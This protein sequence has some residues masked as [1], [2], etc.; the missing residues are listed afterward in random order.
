VIRLRNS[1]GLE[2]RG[3]LLWLERV[4][5]TDGEQGLESLRRSVQ[6]GRPF[7]QPQWQKETAKRL[8]L[9]SA[10][11]PTGRPPKV[12]RN[13]NAAPD[14][15]V[16]RSA[17][18]R[19]YQYRTCPAFRFQLPKG[20]AVFARIAIELNRKRADIPL[21]DGLMPELDPILDL[22]NRKPPL[23]PRSRPACRWAY[24]ASASSLANGF[25]GSS[26]Q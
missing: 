2:Q 10:Y 4:K 23:T 6:R 7:D 17:V 9:E 11:R 15:I 12:G 21:L 25:L 3:S 18:S 14:R 1:S 16:R 20:V 19:V 26:R 24:L 13:Q 22:E 5:E 8:G